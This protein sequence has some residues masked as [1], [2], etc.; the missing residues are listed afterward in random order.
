VKPNIDS[1]EVHPE[2]SNKGHPVDGVLVG[3]RSL[4]PKNPDFVKIWKT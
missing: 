4:W 2:E 1:V 3:V